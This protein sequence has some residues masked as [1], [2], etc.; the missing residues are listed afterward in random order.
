M[1]FTHSGQYTDRIYEK[2]SN[3]RIFT[4]HL[5]RSLKDGSYLNEIKFGISIKTSQAHIM[6]ANITKT[7]RKNTDVEL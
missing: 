7:I 4:H 6:A 3:I 2:G 5:F 1:K